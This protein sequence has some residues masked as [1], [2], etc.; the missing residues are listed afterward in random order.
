MNASYM[1]IAT[2]DILLLVKYKVEHKKETVDFYSLYPIMRSS[3][4]LK[5]HEVDF[6]T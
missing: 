2:H 4:S 1:N 6:R 5:K 3:Y